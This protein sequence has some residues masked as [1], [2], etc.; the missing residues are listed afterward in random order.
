MR[1]DF[2][3]HDGAAVGKVE[4]DVEGRDVFTGC[5]GR[6]D[7]ICYEAGLEK[8]VFNDLGRSAG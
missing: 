1:I 4:C 6:C 7:V 3:K 8:G 2:V 5:V